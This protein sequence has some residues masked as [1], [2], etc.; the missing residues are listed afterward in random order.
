[1]P[2]TLSGHAANP[3]TSRLTASDLLASKD[4]QS[5]VM[6]TAYTARMAEL[7]DWHCVHDAARNY[8]QA[9][10]SGRFPEDHLYRVQPGKRAAPWGAGPVSPRS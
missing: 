6:P 4:G 3:V 8:A 1:M 10:R 9:E 2:A 7:L 5:I